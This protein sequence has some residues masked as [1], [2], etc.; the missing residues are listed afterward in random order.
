MI[1]WW[2]HRHLSSRSVKW[3]TRVK[4]EGVGDIPRYGVFK[5]PAALELKTTFPSAAINIF[6]NSF[7]TAIGPKTF[8]S[9]MLLISST[10]SSSSGMKRVFPALL[11]STSS[12][13]PVASR[14]ADFAASVV[15]GTVTSSSSKVML[16][17]DR[18]A[19]IFETSRVVAKT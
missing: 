17:F 13:P 7:V 19:D 5:R 18:R 2:Q 12:L 15:L 4:G 3:K 16:L 11:K 1:S 14:T 10:V 8:V 6:E 9:N